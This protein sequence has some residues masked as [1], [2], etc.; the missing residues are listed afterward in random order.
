MFILLFATEFVE[1][2]LLV[3]FKGHNLG[4]KHSNKNGVNYADPTCNIGNKGYHNDTGS[5]PAKTWYNNWHVD[6]HVT[7]NLRTAAYSGE[8]VGINAV[9]DNLI[10]PEQDVVLRVQGIGAIDQFIMFNR[11]LELIRK[12][13]EVAM[14]SFLLKSIKK[15]LGRQDYDLDKPTLNLIETVTK[16]LLLRFVP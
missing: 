2:H 3:N 11:N 7:V 14:E 15:A 13:L 16:P 1:S 5:N 10:Q 8:I 12:F 9:R 4:H 6:Y